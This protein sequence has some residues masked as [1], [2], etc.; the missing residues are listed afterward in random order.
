[1]GEGGFNLRKWHSNSKE[2]ISVI[3]AE[4]PKPKNT[5]QEIVSEEDE[6]FAKATVGP[7]NS[8]AKNLNDELVK[9]LGTL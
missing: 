7:V 2:L 6:S 3:N 1:M 5:E 9:V 8:T 4:E